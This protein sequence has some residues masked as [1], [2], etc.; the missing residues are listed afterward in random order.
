MS[1]VAEMRISAY[2]QDAIRRNLCAAEVPQFR[3][4]RRREMQRA[5][6]GFPE[7]QCARAD[8]FCLQR[9]GQERQREWAACRRSR[10]VAAGLWTCLAR[11]CSR[12]QM[13][14]Q[15]CRRGR[16]FLDRRNDASRLCDSLECGGGSG[17]NYSASLERHGFFS[18]RCK[19]FWSH[20]FAAQRVRHP[21]SCN[22]TLCAGIPMPNV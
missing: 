22:F 3:P 12:E 4:E 8:R 19:S 11:Q 1:K 14:A 21:A 13:R 15:A 7:N 9:P 2:V 5:R 10:F 6:C 17:S 20:P 18:V 16:R